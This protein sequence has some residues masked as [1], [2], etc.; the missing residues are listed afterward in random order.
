ML[1]ARDG[2]YEMSG[3]SAGERVGEVFRFYILEHVRRGLVS[4]VACVTS[5]GYADVF[6]V[7]I[8]A[9][10]SM[11]QTGLCIE[12]MPCLRRWKYENFA[13]TISEF[14][15]GTSAHFVA[16]EVLRH[17]IPHNS[18]DIPSST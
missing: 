6:P 13:A 18:R 16:D 10:R 4:L 15:K 9:G 5:G 7:L 12:F 8:H 1:E 17:T 2:A 3:K 11:R 14:G